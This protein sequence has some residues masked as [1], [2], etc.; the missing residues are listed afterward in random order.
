M[1]LIA[2]IT[3]MYLDLVVAYLY[4]NIIYASNIYMYAYIRRE[5]TKTK[6]KLHNMYM[7]MYINVH[8]IISS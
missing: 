8:I 7:Y 6:T 2:R 1:H 4:R 3:M 5:C